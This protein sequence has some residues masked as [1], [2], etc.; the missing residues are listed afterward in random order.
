M[1]YNVPYNVP[2]NRRWFD[3]RDRGLDGGTQ[4]ATYMYNCSPLMVYMGRNLIS[5]TTEGI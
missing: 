5:K 3:E 2:Y 4:V 1:P